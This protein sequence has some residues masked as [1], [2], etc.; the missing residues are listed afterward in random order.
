M[1]QFPRAPWGNSN[2]GLTLHTLDSGVF[3]PGSSNALAQ[4]GTRV[5]SWP[6]HCWLGIFVVLLG[7]ALSA[8]LL[9]TGQNTHTYNKQISWSRKRRKLAASGIQCFSPHTLAQWP[10]HP[11]CPMAGWPRSPPPTLASVSARS[12]A[13]PHCPP[14]QVAHSDAV[15]RAVYYF[16]TVTR[17]T[18]WEVPTEAAK[19][20]TEVST[21]ADAGVSM[22][23]ASCLPH[24]V[25]RRKCGPATCW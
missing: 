15:C 4:L 6:G 3:L 19:A 13:S 8:T 18:Q 23:N 22:S 10:A 20:A 17:K 1:R 24:A 12:N 16:N 14:H 5:P 25:R 7:T 9:C 21:A 2:L 11:P